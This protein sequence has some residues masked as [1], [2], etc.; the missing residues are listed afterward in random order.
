MS[1]LEKG[2]V[3]GTHNRKKGLELVDLMAPLGIRVLTLADVVSPLEVAE[4][5]STFAEN[6][7]LKATCQ[8]RHL[9]AW[10]LAEDSGLEVDVLDGSPGVFSAR[11]AGVNATDEE[12]NVKLLKSLADVPRGRRCAHYACYAVLADSSGTVRAESQ[13]F[14]HGIIRDSPSGAHGFGY[15]PLFEVVEYHRTFGE[16]G[17]AAKACLSHRGRAVR[18]LLTDLRK[19]AA[20][21]E[22][23][24]VAHVVEPS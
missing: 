16:I 11:Y 13:G 15:D 10:V 8:A 24:D 6:A 14:C 5:G 7:R 1:L 12:N 3:V 17:P 19:L 18:A 23:A 4:T 22:L 21:G 2:L 9:R 20:Q